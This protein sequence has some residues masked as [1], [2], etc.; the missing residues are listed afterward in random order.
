MHIITLSIS[1]TYALPLS[2]PLTSI[3][4]VSHFALH[5]ILF[6]RS[7]SHFI[8]SPCLSFNSPLTLTTSSLSNSLSLL[9]HI[10]L[11][12]LSCPFSYL[13][14]IF[15]IYF[16]SPF[17]LPFFLSSYNPLIIFVYSSF[18]HLISSSL[19]LLLS[20]FH[21]FSYS[22]VL[23][24]LHI[25]LYLPFPLPL[26]LSPQMQGKGRVMVPLTSTHK[27]VRG[28]QYSDTF[29]LNLEHLSPVSSS[30]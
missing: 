17:P 20:F 28:P 19:L 23:S 1:H 25:L 2:F 9:Y 26:Y 21:L 18:F 3:S 16:P 13:P 27:R 10:L 24:P 12:P 30:S 22:T 6:P 15:T 11:L 5:L 4:H 7:L 14:S 29:L 8:P